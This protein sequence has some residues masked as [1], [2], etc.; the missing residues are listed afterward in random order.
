MN[1]LERTQYQAALAISGTWK[2]TNRDK[3]YE[4]LGWETLDQRR[5]F[6]RLTQF[7]KIMNNLT[8]EYLK[9]PI[10][11]LRGNL[12]GYRLNNVIRPL[13]CR[14]ERYRNSF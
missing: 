6:R 8:P 5:F 3:I 1:A 9:I 10:P 7:Y 14:T 4:E 12:F 13:A 2:G 11:P